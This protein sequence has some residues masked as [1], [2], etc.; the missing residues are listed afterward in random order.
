MT[1]MKIVGCGRVVHAHTNTWVGGECPQKKRVAKK[2]L[3]VLDLR[4]L[5]IV[6]ESVSDA[7]TIGL[8]LLQTQKIKRFAGRG[9]CRVECKSAQ[10]FGP[11]TV[12]R[13]EKTLNDSARCTLWLADFFPFHT[14]VYVV[15]CIRAKANHSGA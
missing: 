3:Q 14:H 6:P 9:V 13:R 1:Q 8:P 5:G 11:R 4:A 12:E 2:S 10:R 7:T 15:V